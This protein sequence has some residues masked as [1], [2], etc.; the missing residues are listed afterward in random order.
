MDSRRS[1]STWYSSLFLFLISSLWDSNS[2]LTSVSAS[3]NSSSIACMMSSM[4]FLF[5]WW[6]F[7]ISVF[8]AS[9]SPSRSRTRSKNSWSS[10][11]SRRYCRS[12]NE[13]ITWWW[14]RKLVRYCSSA[15]SKSW[16]SI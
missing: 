4:S 16:S 13:S 8:S 2:C 14:A 6:T 5:F 1:L 10:S 11:F 12:I 3:L 7:K 9:N 15:S